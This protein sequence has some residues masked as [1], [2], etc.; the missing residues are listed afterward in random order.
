MRTGIL[1]F[2]LNILFQPVS[3]IVHNREVENLEQTN[4]QIKINVEQIKYKVHPFLFF[5]NKSLSWLYF[6]F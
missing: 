3:V 2:F 4:P 5:I 1:A 6:L